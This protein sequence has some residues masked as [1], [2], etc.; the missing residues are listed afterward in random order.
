MQANYYWATDTGQV[1]LACIPPMGQAYAGFRHLLSAKP[2]VQPQIWS[3]WPHHHWGKLTP[4]RDRTCEDCKHRI[5]ECRDFSP[6]LY[7]HLIMLKVFE[8]FP[9]ASQSMFPRGINRVTGTTDFVLWA[10]PSHNLWKRFLGGIL[11][12]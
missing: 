5:P 2:P 7:P 10:F 3:L 12:G 9:L 1:Y 11:G 4:H 6:Y 8:S